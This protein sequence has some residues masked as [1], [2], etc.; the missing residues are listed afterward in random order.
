MDIDVWVYH[1][2]MKHNISGV[3]VL[4]FLLIYSDLVLQYIAWDV[5]D[6]NMYKLISQSRNEW[7]L[8]GIMSLIYISSRATQDTSLVPWS[9]NHDQDMSKWRAS[10]QRIYTLWIFMIWKQSS[11][12]YQILC[13]F[14]LWQCPN[15]GF[16]RPED[17]S[18]NLGPV[19]LAKHTCKEP[20]LANSYSII[21]Y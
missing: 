15:F 21:S 10:E 6:S 12:S 7:T 8:L 9:R 5:F 19:D 4:H 14:I 20:T 2:K 1:R 17:D 11:I 18:F 3:D 13:M 16:T